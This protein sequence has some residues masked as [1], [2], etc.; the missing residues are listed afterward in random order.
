MSDSSTAN[1]GTTITRP[2]HVATCYVVLCSPPPPP[3]PLNHEAY[4]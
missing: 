2:T 4:V 3:P 1:N